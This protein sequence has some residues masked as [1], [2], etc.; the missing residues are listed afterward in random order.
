MSVLVAEMITAVVLSVLIL[1]AGQ[2]LY[3]TATPP[4]RRLLRWLFR[5]LALLV[6]VIFT[7][8]SSVAFNIPPER[9]DRWVIFGIA[10][11]VISA[12]YYDRLVEVRN[13][14]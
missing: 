6:G 14:G 9:P 8:L 4:R 2:A 10:G 5:L 12:M 7:I 3:V 1:W 13:H 11:L